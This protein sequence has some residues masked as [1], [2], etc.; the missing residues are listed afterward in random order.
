MRAE[1]PPNWKKSIMPVVWL[2]DVRGPGGR[3]SRFLCSTLG[4]SIDLA[5]ADL[6]RLFVNACYELT[7][8][9]VP[10]NAEVTPV[11]DYQPSMFGFNGFRKGVKVSDHALP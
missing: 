4:A 11:G 3:T 7:G 8:L 9:A 6:R 1:D 5:S 10:D 2:R